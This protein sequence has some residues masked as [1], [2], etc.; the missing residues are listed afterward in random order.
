MSQVSKLDFFVGVFLASIMNSAKSVPALFDETDESKKI[1]FMSDLGKYNVY[2]KYSTKRNHSTRGSKGKEIKYHN[3]LF[4]ENE[5]KKFESFQKDGVNNCLA[6]ICTEKNLLNTWIV[7]IEYEKALKC[8]RSTTPNGSRRIK[9]QRFGNAHEFVCSGVGF[10][11][12]D[13]ETCPYDWRIYFS[14]S[15]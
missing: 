10:K 5:Y 3:V 8:L 15:K 9:I 2:V 6:I 11:N 13:N 7:V 1:E 12:D 4:T 14:S